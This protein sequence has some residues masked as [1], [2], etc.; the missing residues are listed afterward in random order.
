MRVSEIIS[1]VE[2]VTEGGGSVA[3]L[4]VKQGEH[5]KDALSNFKSSIDKKWA[6]EN[7]PKSAEPSSP[8]KEALRT[9]QD[10]GLGRD[11][12]E[13]PEATIIGKK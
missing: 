9:L 2:T 1:K 12:G 7:K 3:R 5:L 6:E 4:S 11:M 10:H 13:L 8:T